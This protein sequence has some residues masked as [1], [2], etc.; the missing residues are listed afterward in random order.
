MVGGTGALGRKVV[1]E[2]LTATAASG[3]WFATR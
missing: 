3:C 2:L 1:G